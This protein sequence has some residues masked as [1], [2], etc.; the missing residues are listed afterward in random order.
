VPPIQILPS[1]LINQIAAGEAVERG[2]R[3]AFG[4]VVLTV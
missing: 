1:D 4:K 2:E 3:E